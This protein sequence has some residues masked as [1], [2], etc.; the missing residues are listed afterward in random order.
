[1][2]RCIHRIWN[3]LV[4][5]FIDCLDI[6]GL[7]YLS[8]QYRLCAGNEDNTAIAAHATLYAQ[9]TYQGR[10]LNAPT[11]HHELLAHPS[12]LTGGGG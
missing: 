2:G 11:H 8:K 1:M 6:W 7:D 10:D 5:L 3:W 12:T 4:Y 9:Q